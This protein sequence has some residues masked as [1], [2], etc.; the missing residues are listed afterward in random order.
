MRLKRHLGILA[1]LVVLLQACALPSS[2]VLP[3]KV[4]EKEVRPDVRERV[5]ERLLWLRPEQKWHQNCLFSKPVADLVI[6]EQH[7]ALPAADLLNRAYWENH[8]MAY[9]SAGYLYRQ[10]ADA[11]LPLAFVRLGS[12]LIEGKG[13]PRNRQGGAELMRQAALLDCAEGQF[14]YADVLTKGQGVVTN[15]VDAW[16]WAEMARVQDH[17]QGAQLQKKIESVMGASQIAL[18][19]ENAK[20]L[21]SQLDLLNHGAE[22][23]ILVQCKTSR[24]LRPFVTRMR[25]CYAMG[26]THTPY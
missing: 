17:Q 13:V 6:G 23:Q 9:R 22:G 5:N 1:A 24:G 7:L 2:V 21:R 12:L 25:A 16:G 19:K 15:L 18:A 3:P 8:R 26:G 20:K 14:A 10:A 11:G 4:Q